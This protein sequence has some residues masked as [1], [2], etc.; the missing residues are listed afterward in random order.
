[1]VCRKRDLEPMEWKD[2]K[3]TKRRDDLW[4][5]APEEGRGDHILEKLGYFFFG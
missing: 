4:I 3:A 2:L 1:M 5:K